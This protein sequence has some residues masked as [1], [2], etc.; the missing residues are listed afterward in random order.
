MAVKPKVSVSKKSVEDPKIEP[1]AV[2]EA[3]PPVVPVVPVHKDE[4][5]VYRPV[6]RPSFQPRYNNHNNY[7]QNNQ[8]SFQ[9]PV[10]Q[11]EPIVTEEM[12][13][14]F[15]VTGTDGRGIVRSGFRP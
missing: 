9:R 6:M 11:S 8:R 7:Q 3:L 15:D 10:I 2:V 1:V 4:P 13:G 12:S 14:I 5:L